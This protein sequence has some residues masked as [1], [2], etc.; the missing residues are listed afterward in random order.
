MKRQQLALFIGLSLSAL[1]ATTLSTTVLAS[2]ASDP[3]TVFNQAYQSYLA[4]VKADKT[5]NKLPNLLTHQVKLF[6]VKA[7]ITPLT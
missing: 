1:S 6:M 7:Q 2:Q 5:Y 3:Q 4:A